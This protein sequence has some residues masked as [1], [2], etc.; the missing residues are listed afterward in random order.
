MV[1]SAHLAWP[2][3]YA[4]CLCVQLLYRLVESVIE[5][6]VEDVALIRQLQ[7]LR[8]ALLNSQVQLKTQQLLR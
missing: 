4:S 6:L 7:P 5:G 2:R 8:V 1:L 3:Q